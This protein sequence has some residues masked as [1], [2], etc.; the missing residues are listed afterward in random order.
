[1]AGTPR[2][3][4]TWLT[5]RG[6]LTLDVPRIMGIVNVTPDSFHDGGRHLDVEAAVAHAMTLLDAGADLLDIGGESTRPGAAPVSVQEELRRV[7]PVL[8][9]LRASRPDALLSIDTV[10][11]DVA[12][13]ALAEGAAVV[14]DVS[15]G[16][17][18]ARMAEVA[19]HYGAGLVLMH[20]RGSVAEMAS[21]DNAVY[22]SDPVGD[23]VAELG[24]QAA[25]A[26]DAG[27]APAHIVLDPGL[28]FSKRT[29]HSVAVIAQLE[30]ILALGYPVLLGPSRKRFAGELAGGL[31]PAQRL[32]G[33]IAACVA[34]LL[35]GA[36]IF[37]VHDVAPVRRALCVAE[38]IQH[39]L[40]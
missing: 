24:R 7:Q 27:V 37:R 1:M 13:M 10:K 35:R 38:A 15:G 36:R 29:E 33:T 3:Q 4:S 28:G 40:P 25:Q 22:G 14:N 12:A 20:S 34:G 23:V 16:R 6:A 39:A 19:A 5:A 32:E 2:A 31:P 17:L 30:R 11:S 26:R 21:Y 8:E 9:R 18:D